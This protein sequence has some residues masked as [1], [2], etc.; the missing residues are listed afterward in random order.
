[1]E[2][3]AASQVVIPQSSM[4]A[5]PTFPRLPMWPSIL[6]SFSSV[7]VSRLDLPFLHGFTSDLSTYSKVGIFFGATRRT[8][9]LSMAG[10]LFETYAFVDEESIKD[11][12]GTLQTW[13]KIEFAW[14][15]FS[16]GRKDYIKWWEITT[17]RSEICPKV[18]TQRRDSSLKRNG[19]LGRY[20]P[21][22]FG[23][24]INLI[25]LIW[26][27]FCD[28]RHEL[29]E[30]GQTRFVGEKQ[31]APDVYGCLEEDV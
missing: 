2:V 12:F 25:G 11:S 20:R 10:W 15:I 17:T 4:R 14:Y 29:P 5:D 7:S 31:P 18:A 21:C 19:R 30:L 28:R 1:M 23:R 24:T 6:F 9:V 13:Q 8:H 22:L 26:F 27:V 16:S 3:C